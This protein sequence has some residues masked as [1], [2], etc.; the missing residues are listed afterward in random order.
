M[1][2]EK[3]TLRLRGSPNVQVWG[4]WHL[5]SISSGSVEGMTFSTV[6]HYMREHE[7]MED[8]TVSAVPLASQ[9]CLTNTFLSSSSC[10]RAA[11]GTS[12]TQTFGWEQEGLC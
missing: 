3:L 11:N 8:Y 9:R 4:E 2:V 1:F 5:S 12:R 7:E 10:K 6:F